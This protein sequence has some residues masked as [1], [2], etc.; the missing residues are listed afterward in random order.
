MENIEKEE[1]SDQAVAIENGLSA[2][3]ITN[4]T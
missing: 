1:V 2:Q 4:G 3:N